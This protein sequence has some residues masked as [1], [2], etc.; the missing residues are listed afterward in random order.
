[1]V[2]ESFFSTMQIPLLAGRSFDASDY[3]LA[4]SKSGSATV[5]KRVIVDQAFVSKYLGKK[6]PLGELL[7]EPAG[8]ENEP[9]SPGYAIIGVF[10]DTKYSDLRREINPLMYEPQ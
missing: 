10:R 8:T 2:G 5:P 9:A 6:S 1:M 4:A 7:G 3:K